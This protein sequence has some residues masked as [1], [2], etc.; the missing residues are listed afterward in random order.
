[1]ATFSGPSIITNGLT[2]SMDVA[3]PKGINATTCT[4]YNNAKQLVNDLVN[5][6]TT[7]SVSTLRLGN[8]TYYTAFAIDYPESSYG[9]AAAS[10]QGLT[11][12]FNVTAG[13]K[14]YDASR[15]LHLWVW[16]NATSSWVA[17]SYFTGYRLAGHCYD[18]YAGADAPGG[19]TAELGRFVT[20]YNKIKDVFPDCTYIVAGSHRDSYRNDAVRAILLDL[21]MPAGTTLDSNA[22]IGA[23]EWILI[24]KP[25]LGSG[26]GGWVY[27]NY[28]TNPNQV[29]HMNL[30]L[31]F[32]GTISNYLTFDGSTE[33]ITIPNSTDFDT[34]TLTMESWSYPT[35]VSQNGF[36]FEKGTVNTQYSNFYNSDGTFYFRTMGISTQDLTFTGSSYITANAWN[37]IVCTYASGT[38]RVYVNNVLAAQQT[39]LTGTISTN[40]S[41]MSIGV[42]GGATGARGY[43]FSGRIGESRFYN[44]ALTA[45]EVAQNYNSDRIRYGR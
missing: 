7:S 10:R 19:Y 20:D 9:G 33:F 39:G 8:L 12:G 18:T 35:T 41:G 25:G 11:Q 15:A 42:Y 13:S 30:A 29:A 28:S 17:D 4:G 43:Y 27:E 14:T 1:M 24:G 3:N 31:P 32:K 23:P 45:D 34:Q 2:Y 16:N 40:A 38:K 37:H 6:I 22:D 36:L 26:N 5:T 44:R 21:G